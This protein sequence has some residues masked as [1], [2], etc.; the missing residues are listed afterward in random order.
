MEDRIPGFLAISSSPAF[1][2]PN[3]LS[4]LPAYSYFIRDRPPMPI[5]VALTQVMS[6]LPTAAD[7]WTFRGLGPVHLRYVT[8]LAARFDADRYKLV[9]PDEP[10]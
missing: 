1:P 10:L 7:Y 4:T 9:R 6:E 8:Q 3:S 2:D 5:W